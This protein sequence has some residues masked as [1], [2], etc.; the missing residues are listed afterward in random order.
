MDQHD[1]Y[2]IILPGGAAKGS[3]QAGALSTLI[4]SSVPIGLIVGTSIGA[5]NGL[6]AAC[7][8][9]PPFVWAFQLNSTASIFRFNT[10]GLLRFTGRNLFWFFISFVL[11]IVQILLWLVPF[12]IGGIIYSGAVGPYLAR[13]PFSARIVLGLILFLLAC[14]V[15]GGWIEVTS[16]FATFTE[17]IRRRLGNKARQTQ[18]EAA[19]DLSP[20]IKTTIPRILWL[21][22]AS[23]LSLKLILMPNPIVWFFFN[24]NVLFARWLEKTIHVDST[25]VITFLADLESDLGSLLTIFWPWRAFSR[26]RRDPIPRGWLLGQEGSNGLTIVKPDLASFQVCQMLKSKLDKQ[27]GINFMLS[28]SDVG[29]GELHVFYICDDYLKRRLL[30]DQPLRREH[31]VCHEILTDKML[32][33]SLLASAAIPG[34]FSARKVKGGPDAY[35]VDGGIRTGALIQLAIELGYSRIIIVTTQT[36]DREAEADEK[37]ASMRETIARSL[38]TLIH[39]GLRLEIQRI[40]GCGDIECHLIE[41]KYPVQG[42]LLDFSIE[43]S[44]TN[45]VSGQQAACN[46]LRMV[47]GDLGRNHATPCN[48]LSGLV[49]QNETILWAFP[50]WTWGKERQ[51]F[52]HWEI[53]G[54]FGFLPRQKR[55]PFLVVVTDRRLFGTTAPL[56]KGVVPRFSVDRERVKSFQVDRMCQFRIIVQEDKQIEI[57]VDD[58]AEVVSRLRKIWSIDFS[59]Q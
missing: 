17:S 24:L 49:D 40:T 14:L 5:V 25:K 59:E 15:V 26:L 37:E 48:C 21:L 16:R 33:E 9:D 13:F 39:D 44:W 50:A 22:K 28:A 2:A 12:A 32:V 53:K 30:E 27:S 10:W 34:V 18:S 52:L 38:S 3:F 55:D 36:R 20:L 7:E 23:L 29:T 58:A 35:L 47:G 19:L 45:I 6:L 11:L 46:Y 56:L 4:D 1:K 54:H 42:G 43:N 31:V 57:I 51:R 8:S 41:A